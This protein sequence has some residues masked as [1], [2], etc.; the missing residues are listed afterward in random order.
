ME[1]D[2]VIAPP[3][4][5]GELLFDAPWQ[6]RVFGIARALCDAGLFEWDEFRA[7]LIE[8]V[9]VWDATHSPADQ[10]DYYNLFLAALTRLLVK[11]GLCLEEDLLQRT[12]DLAA[13]PHG[14]DH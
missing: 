1:L 14:H 7:H 6:G 4:E 3:M 8:E 9:G 11:K 5:N 13:R 2:G 12:G 10:Y